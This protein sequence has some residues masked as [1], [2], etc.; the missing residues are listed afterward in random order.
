MFKHLKLDKPSAATL[1]GWRD[2]R[3]QNQ[4]KHPVR[5][6][7]TETVPKYLSKIKR[8][9]VAPFVNLKRFFYNRFVERH[10]V[11]E[12]DLKPGWHEYDEKMLYANFQIL[13]DY[14]ELD[15]AS[16]EDWQPRLWHRIIKGQNAWRSRSMGFKYLMPHDLN[17]D[18]DHADEIAKANQAHQELMDLYVWWK[19]TR[20]NRVDPYQSLRW[21]NVH[22]FHQNENTWDW[23]DSKDPEVKKQLRQAAEESWNLEEAYRQED[24]EKLELLIKHRGWLWS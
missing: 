4:T 23:M 9:A 1:Q 12:M 19:D 8:K 2:W 3:K 15:C 11:I 5:Y 16:H 22:G 17:E 10:H 20:P 6:F 13:V 7:V 21:N 14:V 18:P 24:Q